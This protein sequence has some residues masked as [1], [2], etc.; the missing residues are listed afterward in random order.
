MWD[1]GAE[2]KAAKA[3]GHKEAREFRAGTRCH[4]I[5]SE[6]GLEGENHI[7]IRDHT[8]T[9]ARYHINP[10]STLSL[11]PHPGRCVAAWVEDRCPEEN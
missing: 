10:S 1:D 4:D 11:S 3:G 9:C 2:K 6:P 7:R 8:A 5:S